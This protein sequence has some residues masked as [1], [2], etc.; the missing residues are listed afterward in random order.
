MKNTDTVAHVDK[1]PY[2]DLH[3]AKGQFVV[4][5]YD[6]KTLP[7]SLGRGSWGY[8][9]E[10]HFQSSTS[11]K[12]GMGVGQELVVIGNKPVVG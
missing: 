9:C 8:L 1:L 11:G 10:E 5:R 3:K 12:L 7:M 6:A 4:A 2:C